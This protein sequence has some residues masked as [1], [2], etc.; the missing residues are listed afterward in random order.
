MSRTWK[1]AVGL[2]FLGATLGAGCTVTSGDDVDTAGASGEG[3]SGGSGGSSS[4]SSGKGG[5]AGKAGSATGGSAGKA[6]SGGA[7]G[8][9]GGN[10]GSDSSGAG[11]TDAGSA[12]MGEAGT[13]TSGTGGTVTA[14]CD[15]PTG[16]LPSHDSDTCA[17]IEGATGDDLACQ[18]CMQAE[19]CAATKECYGEDPYNV[20]GWGGPTEGEYAGYNEIGCYVA[21][22]TDYVAANDMTCDSDGEDECFSA[23]ATTACFDD[24]TLATPGNATNALVGCLHT[25]CSDKCFG[26]DQPDS[27]AF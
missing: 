6:G 10:A 15:P 22:L 14:T 16:E 12:G 5:S 13:S 11:G 9:T 7:A 26:G 18:Q 20:C 21:C 24:M 25:N 3:A 1:Y 4:G 27:C 2:G 23:C 8:A 19:C 17:P